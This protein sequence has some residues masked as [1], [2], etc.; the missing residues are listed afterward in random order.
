MGS[1]DYDSGYVIALDGSGNMYMAGES[2]AT[3]GS[4]P[5]NAYA[6]GGDAFAAMLVPLVSSTVPTVSEWGVIIFFILLVGSASLVMRRRIRQGS[7]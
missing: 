5:V 4:S 1:S 7:E 6:G 2:D 3:W